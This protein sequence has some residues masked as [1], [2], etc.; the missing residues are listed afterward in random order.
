VEAKYESAQDVNSDV[1][2]GE[3]AISC[4]ESFD[5]QTFET[6]DDLS[7]ICLDEAGNPT[8]NVAATINCADGRVLWW[9]DVAWGYLG[10]PATLHAEGAELV[11]PQSD[12]DACEG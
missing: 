7:T 8:M 3:D 10:E 2:S 12:R 11:A 9:N 4:V 5:G 6:T 1:E